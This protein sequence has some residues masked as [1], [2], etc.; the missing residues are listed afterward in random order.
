MH[1][2]HK[3][4]QCRH[5]YAVYHKMAAGCSHEAGESP[6]EFLLYLA[7]HRDYGHCVD[8]G[9]CVAAPDLQPW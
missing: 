6:C 2:T 1:C 7:Y 5:M 9:C 3:H 4:T 8:H